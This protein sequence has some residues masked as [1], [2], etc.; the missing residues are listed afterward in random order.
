MLLRKRARKNAD[1]Q[2]GRKK[3]RVNDVKPS[4]HLDNPNEDE[5][6][7]GSD[8]DDG[9]NLIQATSLNMQ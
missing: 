5:I 1:K 9:R 7:A 3:P 6:S 8:F 4:S 2:P